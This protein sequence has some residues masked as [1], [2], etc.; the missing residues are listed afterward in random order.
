ME[1][2]LPEGVFFN[3]EDSENQT[4]L[5]EVDLVIESS[6]WSCGQC[7]IILSSKLLDINGHY[8]GHIINCKNG[9][10]LWHN[11]LPRNLERSSIMLKENLDRKSRA[12]IER[13]K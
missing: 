5:L 9:A 2:E 4:E 7:D 11:I 12:H 10:V 13:H 1:L 8:E 6:D 3:L